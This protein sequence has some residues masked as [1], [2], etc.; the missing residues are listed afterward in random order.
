MSIAADLIDKMTGIILD[1][2]VNTGHKAQHENARENVRLFLNENIE[3]LAAWVQRNPGRR[4]PIYCNEITGEVT[5][6]TRTQNRRMNRKM[7]KYR[8]RGL[9]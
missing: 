9:V 7:A 1:G 3:R 4:P 5:W 2:F 6:L 8:R